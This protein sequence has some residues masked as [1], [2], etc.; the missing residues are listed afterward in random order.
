M[1]DNQSNEDDTAQAPADL[2]GQ[3]R[4]ITV[5][6][7]PP[8]YDYK[9]TRH[10]DVILKEAFPNRFHDLRRALEQFNP[11]LDEL[12][13]GGGGRTVFVKRF[14]ESLATQ[15]EQDTRIWGKQKIS[16]EKAIGFEGN[17]T[18]VSKVRSHEIDMFGLGSLEQPLPGIAVEMEWNN[19]DPFFDRDL[20]NFQA[21]HHEGAIAV[22]VVVTRG[23]GLQDLISGVIQSKDGGFKYGGSTT[24]W[25]KLIPRV[26]LGGGG[27][28][29]LLLIGILPERIQGIELAERVRAKLDEAETLRASWRDT[30]ASWEEAKPIYEEMRRE[31]F[32]LMPPVGSE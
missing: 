22:G 19:K 12:R 24:H 17:L 6:G 14:D 3:V 5:S 32:G 26:N 10:A 23:R 7:L 16:I 20:I 28:C 4:D 9:A 29:P 25:D 27:E 21:L 8:G 11:T 30:F 2:A 15:L 31:A 1:P 13:R 18:P